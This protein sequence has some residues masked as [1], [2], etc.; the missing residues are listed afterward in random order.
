MSILASTLLS[1]HKK[2]R[3]M[4]YLVASPRRV[5]TGSQANSSSHCDGLEPGAQAWGSVLGP[6]AV[7]LHPRRV[8]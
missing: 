2:N 4:I 1:T 5:A 8:S 6:L 3:N 7:L